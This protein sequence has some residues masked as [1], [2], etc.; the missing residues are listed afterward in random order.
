[1]SR[2][3]RHNHKVSVTKGLPP[4]SLVHVGEKTTA[5]TRITLIDYDAEQFQEK[6][7]TSIEECF[8]FKD[9]PS[10]TWLN[11]DG[12]HDV[13]LI[14]KIDSHFG[15]HPLVLEDI[16][17]TTQ[18]PKMEDYGEYIYIV[19][20]MLE[21]DAKLEDIHPEQMSLILGS[22]YL[23]SF[24]EKEGDVFNVIRDRLRQNK[25]RVR[26]MGAD[27]LAY[28]L[29]D[30]AI[31]DYFVVLERLGEQLESV[32]FRL[33]TNVH[34]ALTEDIHYFKREMLFLRKHIW[35]LREM[36]SNLQ[37]SESKL[38]KKTNA[39]FL[40]DAYDHTIQVMDTIES[41]RDLLSGMQDIYLT[42]INNRMNEI[43]K[44]L[45]IISTI[46]MPITFIASIYGMN[47][48]HM[49][50]LESPWGYPAALTVITLVA[51]AMLA[52]FKRKKW[53]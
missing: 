4:G 2:R 17:N 11:I 33:M 9:K 21:Y 52:Y 25:G 38:I 16:V 49:A 5:K 31:D 6:E 45:T 8:P 43:M 51:F 7:L 13:D 19:F 20:K 15:I 48:K 53:I 40:R 39:I 1:M 32:E 28:C 24:Q 18:R 36:I 37:K 42:S 41:Y 23:I 14:E 50:E 46:F 27:Y 22:N 44:V 34:T 29:M 26:K 10:V 12:I 30:T 3:I 35:P 47:F